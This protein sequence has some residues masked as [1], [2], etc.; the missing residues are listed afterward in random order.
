MIIGISGYVGNRLTGIGRVLINILSELA[1]QYPEDKYV[2]FRNFDFKEYD[3]LTQYQNI[4]IVDVPYTKESGLKNILW[5]QWLFQKLL[6]KYKCDIAY[7][8]NF[9]LLLWKT[10]PTIVTI[11]DLIEYNVPDKFSKARM[12]YRKQ[13]CD[14]LMAKKSNHIL[15]VSKSSYKDIISYLGVKPSKLTLTL[16]ATDR[17]V[18]KKY[19]KEKI[20]PAI[21]KYNLEYKKYLLFVGT[22]DFPGK[23][24]KTIIEAFFNLRSKNEL[25][26][27]KLVII[28]KNGFNSKVIYDFVNASPF[29]DEVIFTG[30]LN[31]DDLPKYYAG[32][33]IML[34]LS[35]FE[36]FGLPV[37]EAMSCA[38]P[39][40]CSNTS[41]FPEIVEEL[42]VK[43]PPTDVNAVEEKILKILSNTIYYEILS[44]RCYEKSLKY[45]WTESARVYHNVFEQILKGKIG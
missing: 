5:H 7:I 16:N 28:G 18:F 38:T 39:V 24:I 21:K 23:N 3:N 20:I 36:G 31:D 17:N 27:I 9:T 6:K 8:P 41:C 40:I 32:A 43:V 13:V 26:G 44:Q 10:I 14:P 42:D 15:T 33:T 19:S 4:E 34:Y 29:K 37:L 45:S 11:H 25:N 2:L 1:K 22:I 12:F 30:Y 35:L